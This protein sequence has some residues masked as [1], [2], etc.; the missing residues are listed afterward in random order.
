MQT[1]IPAWYSART[2]PKHEHIAAANLQKSMNL[3]VFLPRIRSEKL[4]RRGL[5]RVVEPLFPCYLFV[6][7]VIEESLNAI[8]HTSGVNRIVH[9]GGKIPQVPDLVI[10][11]LQDCFES[12]DV[13]TVESQLSPGDEVTMA[14][15]AF[16]GMSALVL[17]S[18]PARKRVQVL[19]EILGRATPVEVE[20][21]AVILRRNSL[22]DLAPVLA[23]PPRRGSLAA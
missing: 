5:V 18:L 11:E 3:E 1:V 21:E 12:D 20:R 16:A 10:E 15:G 4:T 19:L 2:K 13:I 9:F 14:T 6:R 22:A 17:K 23:A 7:C 8:Q